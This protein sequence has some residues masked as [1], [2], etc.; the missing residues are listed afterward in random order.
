MIEG[1]VCVLGKVY[2]VE[3]KQN[4]A[5]SRLF[6]AAYDEVGEDVT[7]EYVYLTSHCCEQDVSDTFFGDEDQ[8]HLQLLAYL[9][10]DEDGGARRSS[11]R[12]DRMSRTKAFRAYLKAFIRD[13]RPEPLRK[14]KRYELFLLPDGRYDVRHHDD[15]RMPVFLSESE[16]ILFRYLC[17]LRTAEFWHGFEQLRNLHGVY[18]PLVVGRFL[19]R[20]DESIDTHD[21]L[22]RTLQLERQLI[23]LTI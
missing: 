19:E 2:R 20:L 1:E 8:A 15:G 23:L 21:L 7:A 10:E 12:T 13:F 16:Q 5:N 17:F 11:G 6:L 14:G 18:K 4:S 22:N 3:V 9:A